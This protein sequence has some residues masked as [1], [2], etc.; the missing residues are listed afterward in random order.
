MAII[1]VEANLLA[2]I[3][4]LDI[5]HTSKRRM[6]RLEGGLPLGNVSGR[7]TPKASSRH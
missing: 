7:I 6:L 3:D 1:P 4:V 2:L 5:L